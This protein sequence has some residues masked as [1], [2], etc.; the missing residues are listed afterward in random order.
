MKVKTL[1]AYHCQPPELSPPPARPESALLPIKTSFRASLIK[2]ISKAHYLS[3][4]Y[5]HHLFT[6]KYFFGFSVSCLLQDTV[7]PFVLY[8]P[9]F[10]G[11]AA[12]YWDSTQ[13]K[14]W[15]FTKQQLAFERRKLEETER[16]LVQQYPLPDRR[17]LSIYFYH[18]K[19]SNLPP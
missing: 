9:S 12:S 17:L 14:F 15:T 3:T 13:R 19:A 18:R 11:M 16:A 6:L 2:T 4:Q 8:H 7:L 1:T 5:V 10:A